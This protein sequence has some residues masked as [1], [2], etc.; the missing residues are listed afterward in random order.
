MPRIQ[1]TNLVIDD[2]SIAKRDN[3]RSYTHILTHV[4]TGTSF[5]IQTIWKVSTMAGIL[6]IYTAPIKLQDF[7]CSDFLLWFAWYFAVYA[8]K[9]RLQHTNSSET[10][11]KFRSDY[12]INGRKSHV[13]ISYSVDRRLHGN[14]PLH[15]RPSVWQA[16]VWELHPSL[17]ARTGQPLVC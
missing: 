2:F 14:G 9:V 13:R 1:N 7:Y 10:I 17:P 5:P 6:A 15:G 11:R 4:H 12:H 16:S 3:S 8:E